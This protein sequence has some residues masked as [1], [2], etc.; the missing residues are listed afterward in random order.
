MH[1]HHTSRRVKGETKHFKIGYKVGKDGC[2]YYRNF[3]DYWMDNYEKGTGPKDCLN[4]EAYGTIEGVFVSYCSNC[5]L[6]AYSY[7]RLRPIVLD[8]MP[9]GVE[10]TSAE[11]TH[12]YKHEIIDRNIRF[13]LS[14]FNKEV[15][16]IF[17]DNKRS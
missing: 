6:Y 13:I 12:P 1:G 4:C 11:A 10:F 9:D 3:P 8:I 14:N 15:C 5:A 7:E 2:K 17:G 16:K